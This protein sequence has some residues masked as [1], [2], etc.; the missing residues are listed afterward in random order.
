MV[1][2]DDSVHSK[3]LAKGKAMMN[4]QGQMFVKPIEPFQQ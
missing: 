2:V 3:E 4:W 1:E